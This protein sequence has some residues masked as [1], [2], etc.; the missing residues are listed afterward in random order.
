[1]EE[2]RRWLAAQGVTQLDDGAWLSD[3]E[4]LSSND[5]AQRWSNEFL[6]D[7]DFDACDLL[8]LGLGFVD[9]LDDYYVTMEIGFMLQDYRDEPRVHE[10]LMEVLWQECRTRLEAPRIAETI[11]H[12]LWVDWFEDI[13]T[14]ET[15]FA[16]TL[17]NDIGNLRSPSEALLRRAQRVLE[18]SG[19]VPWAMK[20]PVYQVAIEMPE[21]H[22]ALFR[23]LLTSYGDIYGRI[24]LEPALGLLARLPNDL[25]H[26]DTLCTVL[27][28]GHS[29]YY[30]D[31]EAWKAAAAK[32]K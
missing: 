26:Y 19:P 18:N 31:V 2:A 29:S 22:V 14:V 16:Q 21:L 7:P 23:G 9:L 12:W 24:E 6:N 8:R 1:M 3:N 13:D 17:G 27:R 15:A 30:R 11:L 20:E 4:R 25:E 10:A 28:A 32:V 5:V